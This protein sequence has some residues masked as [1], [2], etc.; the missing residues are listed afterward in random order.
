MRKLGL[1]MNVRYTYLYR[2]D[3]KLGAG[4]LRGGN[5]EEG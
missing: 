1:A 5:C 2:L 3:L 4:V